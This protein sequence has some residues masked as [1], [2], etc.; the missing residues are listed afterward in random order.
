MPR[1]WPPCAPRPPQRSG[2][3][4]L[5]AQTSQLRQVQVGPA[6]KAIQEWLGLD[7]EGESVWHTSGKG[8]ALVREG[9]TNVLEEQCAAAIVDSSEKAA[10]LAWV[11][12]VSYVGRKRPSIM[13]GASPP[14]SPSHHRTLNRQQGEVVRGDNAGGAG[15]ASC[16]LGP[17]LRS[18]SRAD[19]GL[20]MAS[21]GGPPGRLR[22]PGRDGRLDGRCRMHERRLLGCGG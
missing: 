22:I 12:S 15:A 1:I 8:F 20:P 18:G 7:L 5:G 2:S 11:G 17:E 16:F 19:V 4:W 3:Y 13:L 21:R 10:K 14:A 9:E 6:R